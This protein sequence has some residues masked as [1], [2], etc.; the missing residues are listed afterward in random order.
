[1]C[2]YRIFYFSFNI[3]LNSLVFLAALWS[4]FNIYNFWNLQTLVQLRISPIKHQT[5]IRLFYR[6]YFLNT[7]LVFSMW[8]TYLCAVMS[9]P[10]TLTDCHKFEIYLENYTQ[11]QSVY[12][13]SSPNDIW[14][15]PAG[16]QIF[17]ICL[18]YWWV[19]LIISD[20]HWLHTAGSDLS[21]Q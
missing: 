19:T 12:L 5:E 2:K 4:S 3:V 13:G 7:S 1:M 6:K 20:K 11:L 14:W 9:T 17:H 8:T 18:L 16:H 15:R 10:C 21:Y